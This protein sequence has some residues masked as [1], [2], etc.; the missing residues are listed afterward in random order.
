M[1]LSAR[2]EKS[3]RWQT[4]SASRSWSTA[5]GP[6]GRRLAASFSGGLARSFNQWAS[7]GRMQLADRTAAASGQNSVI[8]VALESAALGGVEGGEIFKGTDERASKIKCLKVGYE[9]T[10]DAGVGLASRPR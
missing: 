7:A 10:S 8:L 6:A 1:T 3:M 9:G 5:A 4:V 2:V